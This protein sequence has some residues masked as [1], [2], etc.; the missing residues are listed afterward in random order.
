MFVQDEAVSGSGFEKRL[1][2][3]IHIEYVEKYQLIL[4]SRFMADRYDGAEFDRFR[5][6]RV[7]ELNREQQ[8]SD[9]SSL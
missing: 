4:T 6:V 8:V 1:K 2:S 9:D 3:E 7:L 5:K